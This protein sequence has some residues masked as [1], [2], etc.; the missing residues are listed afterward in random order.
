LSRPQPESP[1]GAASEHSHAFL[2]GLLFP[3]GGAAVTPEVDAVPAMQIEIC[4]RK[5]RKTNSSRNDR[6]G[7]FA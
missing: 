2:A 1:G 5:D 3:D 7:D 4:A 6:G